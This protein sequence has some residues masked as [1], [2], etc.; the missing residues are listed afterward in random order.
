MD[1][2]SIY[3]LKSFVSLCV[4]YLAYQFFLQKHNNFD[5]NRAYLL[6]SVLFSFVLPS[7]EL[8]LTWQ[9][10]NPIN[11][12]LLDTITIVDQPSGLALSSGYSWQEIVKAVY[13]A[14]LAFFLS[15]FLWRITQLG[16]LVMRNGI[17]H[18]DGMRVVF[19]ENDIAPF[20]F[21]NLV[22]ISNSDKDKAHIKEIIQ[23]EKAH[24]MQ[25]HSFDILLIESVSIIQWFNPFV[26]LY[27]KSIQQ[28]HEYQADRQVLRNG[29]DRFY[30]QQILFTQT[31]GI[32][33]NSIVNSFNQ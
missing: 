22:F 27:K 19:T 30:Y 24:I 12:I 32:P 26:W 6:L 7:I 25:F 23:H 13:F 21:F 28:I 2:L 29:S 8:T 14:G 31:T 3:I 17:S 10:I 33:Y 11:Q 18:H 20:S 5:L 15:R 16:Y 1:T 4:F 9:P